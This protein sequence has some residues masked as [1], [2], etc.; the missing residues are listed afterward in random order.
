MTSLHRRSCVPTPQRGTGWLL[1][2]QRTFLL[3]F[4]LQAA[5]IRADE[6]SE[7]EIVV[8]VDR[9]L[10][11]LGPAQED[12]A[13]NEKVTVLWSVENLVREYFEDF[14]AD[15]PETIFLGAG[16]TGLSVVPPEELPEEVAASSETLKF[17]GGAITF[18]ASSTDVPSKSEVQSLIQDALRPEVVIDRLEMHFP[19]LNSVVF[20]PL[21]LGNR[22]FGYPGDEDLGYT[23]P[24]E[25]GDGK[26]AFATNPPK[27]SQTEDNQ[28]EADPPV[29]V[30]KAQGTNQVQGNNERKTTLGLATGV[31]L[32]GAIIVL[33]LGLLVQ[34]RKRRMEFWRESRRDNGS[35]DLD[36]DVIETAHKS[37]PKGKGAY[38]EEEP[39]TALRLPRIWG[40][41]PSPRMEGTGTPPGSSNASQTEGDSVQEILTCTSMD[42]RSIQNVESFEHQK[43][44]VDTLKKEMMASNAEIHP[45]M[46]D[47]HMDNTEPCAL[48]PTD[49]SAAAL[50]NTS[51][52]RPVPTWHAPSDS[53][54]TGSGSESGYGSPSPSPLRAMM[55]TL[56][57]PSIRQ[58][59]QTPSST[60]V[61]SPYE[62][63]N[64][65][66]L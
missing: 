51:P 21:E 23:T 17:L 24:N 65:A 20:I 66:E 31:V 19:G 28:A 42:R 8:P 27:E 34:S 60:R 3:V 59:R 58:Q 2:I 33:L 43:R 44:L 62:A 6:P 14:Y 50:E 35:I 18:E 26:P 49:L 29:Q 37:S 11:R 45:Y 54:F 39:E 7:N 15:T 25:D 36:D 9:F 64:K 53:S 46:Q 38:L 41:V 63:S 57:W 32:G 5:L 56:Q 40:V 61:K 47:T 22:G 12:F 4:L 13:L 30:D 10:L 52:S 48:S 55:E 16:I 1:L